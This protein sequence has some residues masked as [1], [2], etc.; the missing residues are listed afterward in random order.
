MQDA[1][2]RLRRVAA[3]FNKEL[4]RTA[5]RF[6]RMARMAAAQFQRSPDSGG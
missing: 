3:E 1:R 2:S 6:A 4:E 5:M